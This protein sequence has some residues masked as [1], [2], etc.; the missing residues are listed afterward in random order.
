M[1]FVLEPKYS[2]LLT[3]RLLAIGA[4]VCYNMNSLIFHINCNKFRYEMSICLYV[5]SIFAFR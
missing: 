4:E 2:V 3:T 5:V 1:E